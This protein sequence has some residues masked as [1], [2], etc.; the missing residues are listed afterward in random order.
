MSAF[1]LAYLVVWFGVLA[2]LLR[3]GARQRHLEETVE[4]LQAQ[5]ER[6]PPAALHHTGKAA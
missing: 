3:L 2:Y 5:L 6:E 4:M 1:V